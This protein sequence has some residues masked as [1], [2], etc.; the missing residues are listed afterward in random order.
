MIVV[1]ASVALEILIRTPVGIRHTVRVAN[2][3]VHAPHLIDVEFVNALRRLTLTGGLNR[4]TAN[5][6]LQGMRGWRL[7]RHEHAPLLERIWE[8]RNSVSAYDASYVV[9][10]EALE[11]PLLTFDAKLSRAH[12]HRARIELLN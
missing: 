8:M 2:E 9:L 12:G 3:D 7:E 1:D 10:A 11:A 5:N 6:A 4:D